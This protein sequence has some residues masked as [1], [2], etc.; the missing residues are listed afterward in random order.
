MKRWIVIVCAILSSCELVKVVEVDPGPSRLVVNSIFIADST[1]VVTVAQ[2]VHILDQ[3]F[4][5]IPAELS[6]LLESQAGEVIEFEEVVFHNGNSEYREFHALQTPVAGETY[7]I[8]VSSPGFATV[9][10]TATVPPAVHMTFAALDSANLIPNNYD[11][12]GS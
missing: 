1:W 12:G 10:S 8:E 6:I 7:R 11:N 4:F 3:E 5:Q 2:T 9:Y